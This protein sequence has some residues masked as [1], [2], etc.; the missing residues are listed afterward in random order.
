MA[1]THATLTD[2]I[3]ALLFDD[4][5]LYS[6]TKVTV[7]MRLALTKMSEALVG[8]DR[9]YIVERTF[10]IESRTGTA[11]TDTSNALVDSGATFIETVDVGKVIYNTTDKTWAVVTAWVSATELTLSKDI[12]VDGDE[13][14]QMFNEGCKNIKQINI[15]DVPDF[16]EIA[17]VVYK[18]QQD[19][20]DERNFTLE[21][22]ILS[23]DIDFEPDNSGTTGADKDVYVSFAMTHRVCTQSDLTGEVDF[24]DGYVAGS[25]SMVIDGLTDADSYVYVGTLFTVDGIRGTYI[26]AT[27]AAISSNEATVTFWPGLE[28]AA[29]NDDGI[30]F[31]GSTLRPNL[32]RI[33]VE[34]TVAKALMARSN[35]YIG[36]VTPAGINMWDGFYRAGKV[37]EDS[38]MAELDKMVPPKTKRIYPKD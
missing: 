6:D 23:L 25:T 36:E 7:W 32:E 37:R 22:N 18:A 35:D 30:T 21:G 26:V 27:D 28:S 31:I 2:E 24:G 14:Y 11:T 16:L 1:K 13:S 10:Q 12:M 17:K 34:L 38:I 4:G 19:P 20:E 3:Q 29:T 5:T 9:Q 8:S 33:V 15:G